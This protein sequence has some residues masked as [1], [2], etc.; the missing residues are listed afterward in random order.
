[1]SVSG[2][3]D[4]AE[5]SW[6]VIVPTRARPHQLAGCLAALGALRAGAE[7]PELIVVDDDPARS[8]G[9]VV[10]GSPVASRARLLSGAGHGPAAARNL[11]L[12]EAR[13]VRVAF[14]DDDCRPAP[15]W[16]ERLG[17]ALDRTGAEAAAGTTR[18][19]ARGAC[20]E[21]S[22]M[23]VDVLHGL[24]RD[25]RGLRFAASNNVAF[26]RAALLELGGFD[27]SF[28]DA[29]GE[30]RDLSARW[31]GSGRR[32]ADAPDAVVVHHHELTPVDF[33]RQHFR[34][35]RGARAFHAAKGA[36]GLEPLAL[37]PGFG[38]ALTHEVRRGR[39]G[40]SRPRL[41]ALALVSQAATAAGYA[42]TLLRARW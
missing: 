19:G 15:D 32:F 25:E 1:M 37:Q 28:P 34:Y 11:G 5:P 21:A 35:G 26:D 9:A 18:N 4:G 42:S 16:L 31:I 36:R 23:V 8:A 7:E 33:W 6:S 13:G 24:E 14:T 38:R 12:R 40:G 27:E 39:G 17:V 22:Q 20:A 41:A 3:G 29:A 2:P 30:D 10:A